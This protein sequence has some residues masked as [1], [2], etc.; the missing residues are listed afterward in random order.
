M[1]LDSN[2]REGWMALPSWAS[3]VSGSVCLESE[4][5]DSVGTRPER[6]FWARERPPY[7]SEKKIVDIVNS[8]RPGTPEIR[9]S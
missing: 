7:S 8:I 3:S 2:R 9:E 5:A 6:P 4:A 1:W